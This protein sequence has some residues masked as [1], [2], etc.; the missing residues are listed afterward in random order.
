[1]VAE[2]RV[3]AAAGPARLALQPHHSVEQQARVC[4][5]H[6]IAH[7]DEVR[8]FPDPAPAVVHEPGRARDRAER[9]HVAV[10]VAD[11]DDPR[12]YGANVPVEVP[13]RRQHPL[14]R[15]ERRAERAEPLQQR[16]AIRFHSV[17]RRGHHPVC[18]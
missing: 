7:E 8:V 4:A 2:Q 9:T 5:A 17:C 1:M 14:G 12:R 18:S 3:H 6:E 13:R 16:S 11:R 15:E 10:E